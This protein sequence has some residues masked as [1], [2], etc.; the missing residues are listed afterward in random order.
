MS[1]FLHRSRQAAAKFRRVLTL[2]DRI[3][4]LKVLQGITLS[5]LNRAKTSRDLRDHEFSV[6]SQWG[7]DGI[8]Q[9]ILSKIAIA[10]KTFIEF[11]VEDFSEANCRFLLIK[12]LWSGFVLDGSPQNIAALR[13]GPLFWR[14]PVAARASFITRENVGALLAESGFDHDLGIL[15]ID[16]DGVDYHVLEALEAWR[17][18]LLIVEY[19]AVF[20]CSRAVTVPY[21]PDFVRSSRHFSNLY[22]GASLPAFVHLADRRGYGLVGINGAGNNAFFVRR[23]LLVAGLDEVTAASVFRDSVFS[24]S[25]DQAGELSFLRGDDRR[26]QIADLPLLD[27]ATGETIRVSDL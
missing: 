11:G 14:Y 24:E 17:P 7:E 3:D 16:I 18:R 13:A 22:A 9:F 1:S 21:D 12:D 23:D 8:I 5:E 27:V 20:G 26:R 10:N 15:S 6:F 25:R 2:G 4:Q 19:N